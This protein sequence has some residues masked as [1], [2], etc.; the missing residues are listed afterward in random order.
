MSDFNKFYEEARAFEYKTIEQSKDAQFYSRVVIILT[1]LISSIFFYNIELKTIL[2]VELYNQSFVTSTNLLKALFTGVSITFMMFLYHH[3]FSFITAIKKSEFDY[4]VK[5]DKINY[6]IEE[7]ENDQ[8]EFETIYGLEKEHLDTEKSTS[9]W[10]YTELLV[11]KDNLNT[12]RAYNLIINV[13]LKFLL[14][15]IAYSFSFYV[16]T[17]N[18]LSGKFLNLK[19]LVLIMSISVP[20]ILF[21]YW[22]KIYLHNYNKI[23]KEIL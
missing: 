22:K 15:W 5:L 4:K 20:I 9:F 8:I 17:I 1:C 21:K 13:G 23:L 19:Y 7:I 3:T 2:G 12:T 6:I 18:L 10:K 11:S 16:F 14:P